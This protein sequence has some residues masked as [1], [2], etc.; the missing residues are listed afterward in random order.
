MNR[1]VQVFESHRPRLFGIA[2]RMLGSR[3]DAED[4]VQDAYLRWHQSATE[5]IHSPV[6]FLVTMTTR[7]CLD[8]LRELKHEREQYVGPWLPEPIVDDFAPS[9]EMECELADDVSV[10]FLAVLERLG[11][12]E[13]AA[14]LLHEVFDY[15]YPEVAQMIGKSEPACRQMIHRARPRV[16]ESRPRFTVTAESRERLIGKFLG[17]VGTGD[18]K[19]VMALLAEDVEYMADGGGKVVAALKILRGPERIG[20]LYHCIARR[21]LGLN[22]RLIRVNGELGAVCT[23]DGNLFSILSFVTDGEHISRIYVIRNPDKLAGV[24]LHKLAA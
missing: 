9:P 14:F 15:D 10:A 6:A 4:L 5:D 1:I 3:T 17:A 18:R 20:W 13:R 11:P 7:L 19:A 16:R 2:Y 23:M 8:R 22:Y 12:E 21:F 24:A